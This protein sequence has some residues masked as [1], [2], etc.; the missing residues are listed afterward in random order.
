MKAA[1]RLGWRDAAAI[2]LVLQ[3]NGR[4]LDSLKVIVGE[5]FRGIQLLL[6]E[7]FDGVSRCY[8]VRSRLIFLQEVEVAAA[9]EQF[10]LPFTLPVDVRLE[11]HVFAKHNG[12]LGHFGLRYKVEVA[13]GHAEL[14]RHRRLSTFFSVRRLELDTR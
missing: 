5:P 6:R 13:G 10:L 12:R 3:R 2:L 11:R 4:N 8:C 7:H 1:G 9:P 14:L